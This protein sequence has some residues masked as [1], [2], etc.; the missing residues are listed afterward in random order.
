MAILKTPEATILIEQ[1][2]NGKFLY[3]INALIH[4][5]N[6]TESTFESFYGEKVAQA[7]LNLENVRRLVGELRREEGPFGL[8]RA[9]RYYTLSFLPEEEFAGKRL[10]DFACG[11][12]AST[13]AL[14]RIFP[15]SF[16]TG[17]ERVGGC[18]NVCNLKREQL[19]LDRVSFIASTDD[20]TLPDNLEPIDHCI[21][22]S[23]YEHFLPS[24]RSVLLHDIWGRLPVGGVLFICQS[25]QRYAPVGTHG[26][27]APM[28]NY[29][30]DRLAFRIGR[31]IAKDWYG[32][33]TDEEILRDGFRGGSIGEIRA[34]LQETDHLPCF[35][36]P[37]RL[38]VKDSI[39]LWILTKDISNLG[40]LKKIYGSFC[41]VLKTI[42]GFT[43]EPYLNVAIRKT[44]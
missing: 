7:I 32:K 20:T 41:R 26:P 16:I 15:D 21:I 13:M 39:H 9:L 37:N 38:G 2:D 36:K 11:C 25:P 24:E 44:D 28:L 40:T 18:I 27:R 8:E 22:C 10:L 34:I 31:W 23:G 17:I 3:Q 30:P 42:T 1:L 5:L 43:I 12:G 33:L 14:A 19:K 4:G 29:L 6:V 35:L